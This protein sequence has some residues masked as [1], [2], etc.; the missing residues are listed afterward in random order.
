MKK[1][2]ELT[3]E[4]KLLLAE[5]DKLDKMRDRLEC[6][7]ALIKHG[8]DTLEKKSHEKKRLKKM[9]R[10]TVF[11]PGVAKIERIQHRYFLKILKLLDASDKSK[12][13]AYEI[14]LFPIYYRDIEGLEEAKSSN[15]EEQL[16]V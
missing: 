12:K 16:K 4:Y 6:W 15:V 14:N 7:E 2:K 11:L 1:I 5:F 10:G 13:L 9:F 8:K 3:K